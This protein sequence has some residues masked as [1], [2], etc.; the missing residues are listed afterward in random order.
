M[1]TSTIPF[2]PS[3]VLGMIIDP[4]AISNLEK[5]AQMN[6]KVDAA[7]ANLDAL[8]REKMSLDMTLQ[9]LVSLGVPEKDLETIYKQ[10]SNLEKDL[11]KAA[12]NLTKQ[13]IAAQKA[14]T[15]N[16]S[17]AKQTQIGEQL[18][19]PVDF[20]ASQLTPMP[21][22]AD[23][24]DMDVQYF[25]WEENRQSSKSNASQVSSFV[26]AKVSSFLGSSYGG[27][28]AATVN[29]S[30]NQTMSKHNIIGTLVICAN[31]T[32]R[33]AQ[34]FSPLVLDPEAAIDT[35]NQTYG[36]AL[37]IDSI[38][39]MRETALN[40][41]KDG[42]GD[43]LPVL[44]GATYGSS[45]VGFVH[46]EHT[47]STRSGQEARSAAVQARMQVEE[48][49]FFEDIQGSFGLDAE[50]SSTV[51]SLMSND[52]IQSHCSVVAMGLIPSIKSNTVESMV[53]GMKDD[54]AETMA[55]LAKLQGATNTTN[56]TMGTGAQSAKAGQKMEKM[57]SDF[58]S[59]AVS[60][61]G[62][63][64]SQKNQVIDLNSLQT[65]LDDY[66]A[67][68]SDGKIGVP[69]NFYVKNVTKSD[70]AR[71]WMQKHYPEELY[72]PPPDK[73]GSG[74]SGK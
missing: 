69:I 9:E 34:I 19:S 46:F 45:F 41:G 12:G 23:S 52:T 6:V 11:A 33:E 70:I 47:Q 58:I 16:A 32:S 56:A 38:D 2:D 4:S 37:K 15:Q 66:I 50:T 55:K 65:A 62:K 72:L 17:N 5:R 48:D 68:A 7:R 51:K 61:V 21:I 30:A 67:K 74:G 73:K 1:S 29:R 35:Y 27:Q 42:K 31:C 25:R 22:S 14:I 36:D 54:P 49:L 60:S 28:V 24:L 39:T 26:G 64:D 59:A 13:V 44:I 10:G 63:L 40:P 57:N 3:L 18:Q 71:A 8:L 43:S 20:S 53:M